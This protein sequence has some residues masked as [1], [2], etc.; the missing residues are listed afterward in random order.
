LST[1]IYYF[2]GTGNSLAV[3]RNISAEMNGKVISITSVMDKDTITTDAD[4]IGII[5][6][7]YNAV[8]EGMPL[9]VKRFANKLD[10][11]GSKYIFAVCTSKGWP[12]VTIS[13]LGEIVKAHGG[14]LSAGFSVTMPDNS[15]PSTKEEQRKL[16]NNSKKKLETINQYLKARKSGRFE[17]TLFFNLIMVPFMSM[18]EKATFK[19]YN[20]LANSTDLSYDELLPLSD[21]SFISDDKC[22][23]CGI[24]A[25]ICPAND[26]EMINNRPVWQNHCESCLACVNWCPEKAIHG[27]I[28][29]DKT[30]TGYHHPD[31]KLSD[32]LLR[33]KNKGDGH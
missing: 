29:I 30:S 8:F 25:K 6:P 2:S 24:C 16:F 32:M 22:N 12:R 31:I 10:N 17:N 23:G 4:V 20:K 33:K 15:N 11:I 5:F 19:L 27:G 1:E 9:M 3:A 18:G 13:K 7:V 28:I 21:R 14:K 26:I